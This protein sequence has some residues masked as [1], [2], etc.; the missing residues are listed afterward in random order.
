MTPV[1]ITNL[2]A[3]TGAVFNNCAGEEQMIADISTD[4]RTLKPGSLF[5]A[6]RGEMH[7]GHDHVHSAIEAGAN[8]VVVDHRFDQS[9]SVPAIRVDN[10][11]SALGDFANWYRQQSDALVIGVTG[12]VGKTTTRHL[13]HT[14]L[15]ESHTGIESP[16]NFNNEIGVP[17]S[18]LNLTEDDEFAVLELAASEQG[19]IRELADIAEPEFG[20]ITNI[21][22]AHIETFGSLETIIQ[23]KGE[24]AE[25]ISKD[26][27]LILFGDDSYAETFRQRSQCRTIQVGF[28][29]SNDLFAED[30]VQSAKGLSFRVDHDRMFVPAFG[31]HHVHSALAAIAI[32]REIGMDAESIR[33]ALA[34]YLPIAGR[35]AMR[36]IGEWSV[37][38]DTYNANPLSMSAAIKTLSSFE[39]FGPRIA[40]LGDMFELGDAS[41]DY[42]HKL[43]SDVGNADIDCLLCVGEFAEEIAAG[44]YAS[45]LSSGQIATFEHFDSLYAILD[46]WL[47]QDAV[48]L[49]KGSRGMRMERVVQWLENA[50][51]E[52]E[53]DQR[54]PLKQCA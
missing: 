39:T 54:R 49:V 4:S 47:E 6:I 32:A 14:V 21:G 38:D 16:K 45:G 8:A 43:G 15:S 29:Q 27:L 51:L 3:A 33:N 31:V 53:D 28:S 36:R 12:S 9:I 1:S 50:A 40:V 41:A 23:T 10:T 2:V 52:I 26:G 42:H 37:I 13:I 34:S 18:L 5:W 20:V 17:L 46:C 44:A 48:V 30:I 19:N 24:L 7:D 25:S 11:V 35:S 22:P